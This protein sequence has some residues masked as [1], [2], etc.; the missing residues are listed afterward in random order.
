MNALL[1]NTLLALLWC[2]LW[3]SFD[4]WTLVAGFAVG[5]VVVGLYSRTASIR[6]Y[7]LKLFHLVGFG[8]YFLR[9]LVKSNWQI[10]KEVLRPRPSQTPRIVRYD[11]AG[12]SAVK[13]TTLANAIT[14]TPGTL[15]MDIS[16]DQQTLYVHCMYAADRDAAVRDLDE[17]RNRILDEVF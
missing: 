6:A 7:G 8:A 4:I 13:I 15:V 3:G 10:A 16:D 17:L 14:L 5:Y 9:I 1:L 12:L 11:V 2:L